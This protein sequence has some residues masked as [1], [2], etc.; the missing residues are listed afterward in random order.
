MW[1][2]AFS[3]M[4]GPNE[5]GQVEPRMN[6]TRQRRLAA[7]VAAAAVIGAA[8]PA[9]AFELFGVHLWGERAAQ[10]T[11]FTIV[12]PLPYT[13]DI[14][15][16]GGSDDLANV[17]E[18]ASGLWA[19][20]DEPASGRSGLLARAKGDYRRIL[21]AL[22]NNAYYGG[23]ISIRIAGREAA[24]LTLDSPMPDVAPVAIEVRPG[25]RFRFGEARVVNAPPPKINERGVVRDP[26]IEAFRTGQRAN[27]DAIAAASEASIA[28]W[29][30]LSHAKAREVDRSAVADHSTT[31]LDAVVTLDPDRPARFGRT[32][33]SGTRRMDPGFVAYMANLEPGRP[34]D[35]DR[36]QAAEARLSRLGV[37][38]SIRIE[39]AQTIGPDGALDM[40]VVV[41]D[42]RSRTI[43]FGGTISTLDGAGV[44]AFW[45]HRNLFGRAE[46]L[47]FEASATGLG[48]GSALDL[49]YT[50]GVSFLRPGV[51][52]PDTDLAASLQA[53]RLDLDNYREQ[54]ATARLGLQR[55]F[56]RELNGSIAL[57]ATKARFEDIF[58]TRDFLMLGLA[59]KGDYDRRD[60]K[61][62]ATHGY[63]ISA[64]IAPFYELEF[65]NAAARAT[66]E[67]RIYRGLGAEDRFVLAG[68]ARFGAYLGPDDAQSP[69]NQLFFAGGSGSIRGYA[70][71]SIGIETLVNGET[72]DIGGRSLA[73]ASGE[74]RFRYDERFGGVGFVDAGYVFPES[75]FSGEGSDLRI[76][77]G[78]GFR[79]FTG[80]GPLRVD[81][82]TPIN[83]SDDDSLV[84]L[85]VGIGQSF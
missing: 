21:A 1:L 27:A 59:A 63:Y 61:L 79:Y 76:G 43:G 24:D 75:T 60:D 42:R 82:A 2:D 64:E 32:S 72:G 30:Q 6:V 8:L 58:G 3:S 29:R 11:D 28:R 39:E 52:R 33:V 62:D 45:G 81:V 70:Y 12:D 71:R 69:P 77:A 41:S 38:D 51:L 37:F 73:D 22:Y 84:A 78:L 23:E 7:T 15:V 13:V 57:E 31:L 18:R 68:R 10:E 46:S 54:S 5:A 9:P 25:P 40:N 26:A 83:P 50:A 65:G 47:R 74:L 44:E 53:R 80:F 14:V 48:L 20:R 67:G 85:Y 35:P 66:I 4:L 19:G 16:T 49:D 56:A 34:F 17:I 55:S 36:I